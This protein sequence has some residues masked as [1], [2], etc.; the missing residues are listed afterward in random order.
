MKW[1]RNDNNNV[2]V[3]VNICINVC[4]G[5]HFSLLSHENNLKSILVFF[6]IVKRSFHV[7]A[8]PGMPSHSTHGWKYLRSPLLMVFFWTCI[9]KVVLDDSIFEKKANGGISSTATNGPAI[10]SVPVDSR[11]LNAGNTISSCYISL[12]P[13][14][15]C[16]VSSVNNTAWGGRF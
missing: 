7:L 12:S 5:V 1:L 8:W 14:S 13:G 15:A 3:Y 2:S 9:C 10:T 4:R 11:T 16:V 6:Y